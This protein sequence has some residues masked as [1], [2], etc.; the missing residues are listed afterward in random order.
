MQRLSPM[1]REEKERGLHDRAALDPV[2]DG[3]PGMSAGVPHQSRP[4]QLGR[5]GR[6]GVRSPGMRRLR[7]SLNWF[8]ASLGRAVLSGCL[9]LGPMGVVCGAELVSGSRVDAETCR[10]GTCSVLAERIVFYDSAYGAAGLPVEVRYPGLPGAAVADGVFPLLVF[11]HGYQQSYADYAYIWEAL[12]PHGY[13]IAFPDKLSSSAAINI[14]AYARDLLFVAARMHALAGDPASRYFG[15][16]AEE[17]AFMGHSTGGGAAVVAASQSG[18]VT[19]VV[20]LAPLGG[21]LLTPIVGTSPIAAA[22]DVRAP[23][24]I[25]DAGEDCVTPTWTHSRAIYANLGSASYRV[26]VLQGDHCGFSYARGPGQGICVAAEA[27]A[28]TAGLPL[29]GRRG[30]TLG[31]AAQN[32]VTVTYLL[33]WL[34]FHLHGD[35]G[36]W[37]EFV[38]LLD[39]DAHTSY[40]RRT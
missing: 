12:V 7:S 37:S 4:L 25:L 21:L 10:G 22:R 35:A 6:A 29:L 3:P 8:L 5:A 2:S 23:V 15:R 38:R 11:G 34:A 13:I 20:A 18:G 16:I 33:P 24:L 9:V 26:T 14:D 31:P 30:P 28:C 40:E 32:A 1:G 19:T 36:A 27:A 39:A 17:T